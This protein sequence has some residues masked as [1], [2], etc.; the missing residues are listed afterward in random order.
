MNNKIRISGIQLSFI[1]IGLLFGDFAIMNP[2][3]SAMQD[4]W[5]A[6]LIGMLAGGGLITIYLF[7]AKLNPNKTLIEILIWIFGKYLGRLIALLYIWYFIHITALVV[8]SFGEYMITVTFNDTPLVFIIVCAILLI[9][10]DLRKG[11]EVMARVAEI[12]V[13][14]LAISVFLATIL[15]TNQFE[16]KYFLPV[17]ENGWGPVIET[18]FGITTF[19]FGEAVVLMMIFPHLNEKNKLFKATYIGTL[20]GGAI[21]FIIVIR[22]LLVLGPS[23]LSR[24]VF[25]P[26][27]TTSLLPLFVAEPLISA[28]LLIGGGCVVAIYMYATVRGI[29]QIFGFQDYQPFIMP[30]ATIVI[31]V[32]IWIYDSLPQMFAIA[33]EVYPYYALPFQLIIPLFI[34]LASIMKN[35][36]KT[37]PIENS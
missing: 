17:L 5:I 25:P 31:G 27:T 12:A 26:N 9:I 1:T 33:K 19:P 20:I 10:Y 35:K 11:F 16:F 6:Y 21:L 37:K 34:L 4:S 32:S 8:R 15:L 24:I 28:N 22:D 23:L 36:R 14:L 3:R 13:P 7:I 2:A 18:A 30:V 29:Q